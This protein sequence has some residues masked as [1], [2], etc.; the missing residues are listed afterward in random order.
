M[1]SGTRTSLLALCGAVALLAG[2]ATEPPSHVVSAPPPPS[3]NAPVMAAP[4]GSTQTTQTT[5]TTPGGTVVTTQ[6]VPV[7]TMMVPQAPPAMQAET[8]LARPSSDHAWVPGYWTWRNSR[9]EWMAGHWEVPP[10]STA[11]WNTPRWEPEDGA[12]R[13]FEGYWN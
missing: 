12:Y 5:Q 13:F 8:V 7:L 2:C 4:P 9:Y 10:F 11:K 1:R 6:T 3:P